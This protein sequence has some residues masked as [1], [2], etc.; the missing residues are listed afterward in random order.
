ML[1]VNGV[2]FPAVRAYHVHVEAGKRTRLEIELLPWHVEVLTE[3]ELILRVGP[4]RFRVIEE[5]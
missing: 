2:E 3:P 5:F 4:R 1:A